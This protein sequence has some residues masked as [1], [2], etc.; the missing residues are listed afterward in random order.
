MP[1]LLYLMSNTTKSFL[2]GNQSGTCALKVNSIKVR[3][4]DLHRPQMDGKFENILCQC[5]FYSFS[6]LFCILIAGVCVV[7]DTNVVNCFLS[8]NL[9]EK[10]VCLNNE[11]MVDLKSTIA[12]EIRIEGPRFSF[13]HFLLFSMKTCRWQ[14]HKWAKKWQKNPGLLANR[15]LDYERWGW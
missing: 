10:I 3:W 6:H 12:L 9:W 15:V 11:V 5:C 2:S 13:V 8:N 4:P 7:C 1:F 14:S